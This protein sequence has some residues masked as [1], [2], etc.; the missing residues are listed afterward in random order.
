[1][2]QSTE[3]YAVEKKSIRMLTPIGESR[4]AWLHARDFKY[5]KDGIYQVELLLEE[6][7]KGFAEFKKELE[8]HYQG[9]SDPLVIDDDGRWRLKAKTQFDSWACVD[10][11]G[12]PIQLNSAVYGGSTIRLQISPN[13]HENAS[14]VFLEGIQIIN[15]VTGDPGGASFEPVDD[16]IVGEFFSADEA[17]LASQSESDIPF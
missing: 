11:Q 9:R 17:E 15:L 1:M 6:K 4:H 10:A 13:M 16:A 12:T 5:N 7:S 3:D 8:S 14:S 2:G